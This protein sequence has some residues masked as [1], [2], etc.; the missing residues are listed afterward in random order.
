MWIP[1]HVFLIG[2]FSWSFHERYV[3][4]YYLDTFLIVFID[5]ILI[6]STKKEKHTNHFWS[7]PPNPQW[8]QV[9]CQ[10]FQICVL[11]S[12]HVILRPYC[13][14]RR[15][16]S[17]LPKDWGNEELPK[18]YHSN[19]NKKFPKCGGILHIIFRATFINFCST[20]Q[21]DTEEDQILMVWGLWEMFLGVENLADHN[22]SVILTQGNILL[23]ILLWCF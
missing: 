10:I 6:Y 18:T 16:L 20:N 2:E 22:F 7:C 14:R 19:Y 8:P 9:V 3:L 13:I 17:S 15:Y 12:I 23:Y 5:D 11:V 4:K 21:V 1:F